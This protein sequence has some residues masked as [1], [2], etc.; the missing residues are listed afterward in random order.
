L[1]VIQYSLGTL[2]RLDKDLV[3]GLAQGLTYLAHLAQSLVH[4][5]RV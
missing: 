5:V 3:Q 1:G 4:L 2:D